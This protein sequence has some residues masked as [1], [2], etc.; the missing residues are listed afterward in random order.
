MA[1]HFTTPQKLQYNSPNSSRS[2]QH[3]VSSTARSIPPPLLPFSPSSPRNGDEQQRYEL[4]KRSKDEPPRR[5]LVDKIAALT[6]QKRQEQAERWDERVRVTEAL[7]KT[8]RPPLLVNKSVFSDD[9]YGELVKEKRLELAQQAR[10]KAA[11]MASRNDDDE[12]FH[13]AGGG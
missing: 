1:A 12:G 4:I 5:D 3:G 2:A 7:K 8:P 10:K 6:L 11:L 9:V 13:G